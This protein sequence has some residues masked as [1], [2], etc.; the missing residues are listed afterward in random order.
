MD[1]TP[2]IQAFLQNGLLGAC[3][4]VL[5]FAY[6]Q[7]DKSLEENREKRIEELKETWRVTE[8]NTAATNAQTEAFRMLADVIR[9]PR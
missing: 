6:W 8:A 4:L 2:V 3:V 5:A 1:F 7:K 9:Q